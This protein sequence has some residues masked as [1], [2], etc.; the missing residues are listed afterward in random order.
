MSISVKQPFQYHPPS[1]TSWFATFTIALFSS[2]R[3]HLS[4]CG[5]GA[6]LSLFS[7]SSNVT[8]GT[9]T[10]FFCAMP[11]NA[12][13]H[14]V[15]ANKE[16]C[17]QEYETANCAWFPYQEEPSQVQYDKHSVV[18]NKCRIQWL[19]HQKNRYQP[20]KAIHFELSDCR[21]VIVSACLLRQPSSITKRK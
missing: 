7:L 2:F 13:S 5:L 9:L 6:L 17:R 10:F 3:I 12:V 20:L 21:L 4:H 11:Q 18:V 1:H 15:I 8:V 14:T 16:H 19:W